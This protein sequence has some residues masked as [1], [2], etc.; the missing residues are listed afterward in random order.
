MNIDAPNFAGDLSKTL[1][2]TS[3]DIVPF[4]L[5]QVVDPDSTDLVTYQANFGTALSF[6]KL[7]ILNNTN[8]ELVFAPELQDFGLHNIKL[9]LIDNNPSKSKSRQYVISL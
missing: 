2:I 7:N 6:S 3:G 4:A 1:Q 8:I 5:P 9:R